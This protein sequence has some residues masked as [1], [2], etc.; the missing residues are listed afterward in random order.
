[1]RHR[2]G[3]SRLT[4][5]WSAL[6]IGSATSQ[7]SPVLAG[8]I[9][10]TEIWNANKRA[11]VRV[12]V[13]GRD[14]NGTAVRAR[15]G[16]GVIVR[17]DGVVVTAGHVV[18]ADAEWFEQPGKTGVRDRQVE[19]FALDGNGIERPLGQ[20][21]VTV[22]APYDAALLHLTAN[23]LPTA[24]MADAA[25]DELASVVAILWDPDS[26][27]P[28]PVTGDLVP[29]DRGVHGD[30]LTVRL[31]VVEG[32]SGSGVFGADNKLVGIVTNQLG[33]TRALVVPTYLF[34]RFLPP[35]SP[36]RPASNGAA[37]TCEPD[38]IGK[39]VDRQPFKAEN[40]VRCESM[41]MTLDGTVE[42]VAPPGYTIVGQVQ[43]T[44]FVNY[45][46]VGPVRYVG[47]RERVG[48]VSAS[49]HCATPMRPFGPGGW[50][51]A[52]LSGFIE[53]SEPAG[54]REQGTEG[55]RKR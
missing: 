52:I 4:A 3:R 18:G 47:E 7:V 39:R 55:C 27:Q 12:Q 28:E 42:Y 35:A 46:T 30:R 50:A 15:S 22:L 19:I 13:T 45:G 29:T 8:S 38:E 11:V 24:K 36:G 51:R 34:A 9:D 25:P 44:D 40:G 37:D 53:R 54:N 31:G 43:K 10:R 6:I 2:S 20:A 41:G 23:D 48:M 49:L 33:S 16:S 1:M 32:N 21:S 5:F 14:A 17:S 26:H